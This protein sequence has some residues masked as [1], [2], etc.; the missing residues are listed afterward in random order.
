MT[1]GYCFLCDSK[2]TTAWATARMLALQTDRREASRA[3]CTAGRISATR[4]AMIVITTKSSTSVKPVGVRSTRLVRAMK[5]L[6]D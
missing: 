2:V 3:L 5:N 1:A 6:D 4:S